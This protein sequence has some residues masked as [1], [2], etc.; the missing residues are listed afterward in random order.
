MLIESAKPSP[1]LSDGTPMF[2]YDHSKLCAACAKLTVE[3]NNK[4][5]DL[6]M[7]WQIQEMLGL[8]NLYLNGGLHLS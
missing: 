2:L 7:W 8:L 4:G 5:V 1:I 6:V 3:V